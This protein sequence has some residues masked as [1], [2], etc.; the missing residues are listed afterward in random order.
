MFALAGAQDARIAD[1][2]PIAT[3]ASRTALR[4]ADMA[5]FSE[6]ALFNIDWLK[7]PMSHHLRTLI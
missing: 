1:M 4:L 5:S 3:S 2:S 7:I 6:T